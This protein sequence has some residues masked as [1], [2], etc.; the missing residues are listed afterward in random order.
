MLQGYGL[1]ETSPVI[2]GNSIYKN[3]LGSVG[4]VL[5]GAELRIDQKDA[6]D[7]EGEIL[8]RGPHVMKGYYKNEETTAEVIDQDGWFHTGDLGH[9]DEDG[10]LYITGR[11][12]NLIVLGGGK[13]VFPEEVE[14]ALAT[15]P[16]IK[17][18]CVV[19]RK[20]SSGHKEG[21]EEVCAVVVPSDASAKEFKGNDAGML[22]AIEADLGKLSE[23]LATYKRPTSILI[24]PEEFEKTATR[25]VK[26]ALVNEWVKK[27]K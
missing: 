20:L 9:V 15:A 2:T 14:T 4:A 23:N 21:T 27:Q 18:I 5:A 3:K 11:L 7:S 26:R 25:K 12:K 16:T 24:H 6:A 13:K 17:E 19:S 8:T 1:T 22:K 10:F